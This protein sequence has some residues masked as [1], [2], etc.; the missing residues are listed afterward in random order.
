MFSNN[1]FAANMKNSVLRR[2]ITWRSLYF[3]WR[4]MLWR[5]MIQ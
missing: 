1:D 4:V 3:H 5:Q 2:S